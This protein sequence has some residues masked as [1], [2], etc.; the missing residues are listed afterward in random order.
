MLKCGGGKR[1]K[2]LRF[3]SL[4][5]AFRL[6]C[7]YLKVCWQAADNMLNEQDILI[8]LI[9]SL[10]STCAL[11]C[12]LW[13]SLTVVYCCEYTWTFCQVSIEVPPDL[14]DWMICVFVNKQPSPKFMFSVT[15]Q[16]SIP[17]VSRP[18][19]EVV[20]LSYYRIKLEITEIYVITEI[21][22][23]DSNISCRWLMCFVFMG[24]VLRCRAL[25]A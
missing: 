4:H 2:I 25:N 14:S 5:S 11:P 13:S 20:E 10:P 9:N 7:M 17:S 12:R 19:L 22:L 15:L 23:Q 18:L 21:E 1:C 16:Y 24:R 3:L 8:Q 6:S